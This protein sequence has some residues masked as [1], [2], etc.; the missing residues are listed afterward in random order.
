M[1]EDDGMPELTSSQIGQGIRVSCLE[2][3]L[4]NGLLQTEPGHIKC[5]QHRKKQL[6]GH[7]TLDCP[8]LE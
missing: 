8:F 4:N 1:C 5:V 3:L 7:C 6:E 2:H